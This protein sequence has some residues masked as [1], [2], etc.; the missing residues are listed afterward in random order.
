MFDITILGGGPAGSAAAIR[1]AQNGATVSLFEKSVF[2]RQKLCGGFLSPES[3]QDL[4]ELGVLDQVRASGAPAIRRTLISSPSGAC[5]EAALP[6]PGLSLSRAILDQ[7]LLDRALSCGAHI[8][9]GIEGLR[10]V[11]HAGW[12]IIAYGRRAIPGKA[13]YGIQALFENMNGVTD[14]VELDLFPGGYVGLVQ[15]EQGL[16]NLCALTIQDE[17]KQPGQSLDALLKTWTTKNPLLAQRMSTAKRVS[18]WQ[19]V[20]PVVMG[21][22]RLTEPELFYVGDAACV[23]DPFAGE[24]IA[25][26]LRTSALIRQALASA[27]PERTY[28]RLWHSEFDSALRTGSWLRKLITSGILQNLCVRGLE[29]YPTALNWLT[30]RTRPPIYE[31]V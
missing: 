28:R 8:A 5:A 1:L 25:M 18:P 14:Q 21:L 26:S 10:H 24:G 27:K 6:A 7:I 16:V 17:L 20:G 3:L 31:N 2:P 11:R 12:M 19:A 29:R 4:D 22:R 30:E 9:Q 15:Q 13:Y 23:V